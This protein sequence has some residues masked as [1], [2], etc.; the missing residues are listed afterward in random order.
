MH[1]VTFNSNGGSATGNQTIAH[2]ALATKPADP[3]RANFTF[4]GWYR[5]AA[6]TNE[7]NFSTAA[8]TAD[9]TLFAR[10]REVEKNGNGNGGIKLLET[11]TWNWGDDEDSF[12]TKFEYDDQNRIIKISDYLEDFIKTLTYGDDWIKV[13]WTWV[14]YD[15]YSEVVLTKT[16]NNT[17]TLSSNDDDYSETLTIDN[18]GYLSKWVSLAFE[19]GSYSSQEVTFQYQNGNLIKMTNIYIWGG[20]KGREDVFEFKYDD[21]KSPF[22][23][24]KTPKWFM[25]FWFFFDDIFGIGFKNNIIEEIRFG[26]EIGFGNFSFSIEYIY[27]YDSD[28]FPTKQT[29]THKRDGEEDYTRINTFTYITR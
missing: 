5:D 9:V 19:E 6:L 26:G 28:G 27:E 1:T 15:E 29:V 12:V 21:K 14:T 16:G 22:Y 18:D 20:I 10:W 24:C 3:T 2:G 23:H 7:W 11:I 13:T 25:Q 8:V 17:I 4:A